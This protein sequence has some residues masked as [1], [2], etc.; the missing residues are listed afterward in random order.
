MET[1]LAPF[2]IGCELAK[3]TIISKTD[4]FVLGGFMMTPLRWTSGCLT[5]LIFLP[6]PFPLFVI[7]V[8]GVTII[9][10]WTA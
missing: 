7:G 1:P 4:R 6:F 5:L 9:W 3:T 2:A 8:L 10:C